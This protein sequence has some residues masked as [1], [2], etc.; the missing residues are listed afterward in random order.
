[1]AWKQIPNEIVRGFAGRPLKHQRLD[2]DG[3][4]LY[5]P[6][7]CV[8]DDCESE[9]LFTSIPALREHWSGAHEGQPLRLGLSLPRTDDS[10]VSDV[11]YGLIR[12]LNDNAEGN[13]LKAIRRSNDGMHATETWRRVAIAVEK[14]GDIRLKDA[15]YD[16]LH[17]L[18]DRKLP[19]AK[20]A[21]D[22]GEEQQTVGTWRWGVDEYNVRQAF[23]ILSERAPVEKDEEEAAAE[24]AGS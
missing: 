5:E 11:I 17:Q 10:L 15:Q 14:G 13:P 9:T 2:G 1:M 3:E 19:L 18:L 6:F 7:R 20:A 4:G 16:W 23:K 21:K 12:A 8:S 24:A 22:T